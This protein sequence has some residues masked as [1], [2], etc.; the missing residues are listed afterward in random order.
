MKAADVIKTMNG[1]ERL[2]IR[3][4]FGEELFRGFKAL[5]EFHPETA[6]M[7]MKVYNTKLYT[8]IFRREYEG[9]CQ[10]KKRLDRISL[11]EAGVI[12]YR[13]MEEHIYIMIEVA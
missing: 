5:L 7:N 1:S 10:H 6:W 8:E 3:N 11:E 12:M 9:K 2:I 13:D 4:R